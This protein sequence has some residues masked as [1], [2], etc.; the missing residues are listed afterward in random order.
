MKIGDRLLI[1]A[2]F[3]LLGLGVIAGA[4][5]VCTLIVLVAEW[6]VYLASELDP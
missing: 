4:V 2:W 5:V 6:S 3:L 1:A